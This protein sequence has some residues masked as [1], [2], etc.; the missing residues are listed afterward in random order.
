MNDVKTELYKLENK[1][2]GFSNQVYYSE[3]I[4]ITLPD[5]RF[6]IYIVNIKINIKCPYYY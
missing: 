6:L 1:L 4:Y 3:Y 5:Y 2:N